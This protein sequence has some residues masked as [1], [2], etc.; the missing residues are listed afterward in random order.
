M[1]FLR[2]IISKTK[3]LAIAAL[4]LREAIDL[5]AWAYTLDALNMPTEKYLLT[6]LL[7]PTGNWLIAHAHFLSNNESYL[8]YLNLLTLLITAIILLTIALM[9]LNAILTMILAISRWIFTAMQQNIG[10]A[11]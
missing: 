9:T 10:T 7:N 4:I 3:T 11:S 1:N 2:D 6:A 8:T 5:S